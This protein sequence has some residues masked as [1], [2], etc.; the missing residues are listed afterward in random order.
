MSQ[1]TKGRT[2]MGTVAP[3][4]RSR[5]VITASPEQRTMV[6][7]SPV[8]PMAPG[9]SVPTVAMRGR[10]EPTAEP[11]FGDNAPDI[12]VGQELCGYVIRRRLAEGGMGVAYEGQHHKI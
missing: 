3:V 12:F 9:G 1:D 6:P 4:T 7:G 10:P 11:S 2:M 8:P 5:P